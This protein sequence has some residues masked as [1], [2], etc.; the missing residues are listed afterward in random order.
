MIIYLDEFSEY[1]LIH[2]EKWIQDVKIKYKYGKN[3]DLPVGTKVKYINHGYI[4][5]ENRLQAYEII[6]FIKYN[7]N[8]SYDIKRYKDDVI[9]ENIS[10]KHLKKCE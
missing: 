1:T 8:N 6:G 7:K 9:Y 4:S 2:Y 5:T 10:Y 3:K